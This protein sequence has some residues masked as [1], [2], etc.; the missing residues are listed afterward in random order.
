MNEKND[1]SNRYILPEIFII[2]NGIFS[3]PSSFLALI[4]FNLEEMEKEEKLIQGIDISKN[5][6]KFYR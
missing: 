1:T 5:L 4:Q 3:P 6:H 2:Y